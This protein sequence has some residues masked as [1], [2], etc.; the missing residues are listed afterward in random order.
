MRSRRILAALATTGALTGLVACG[1]ND[2][3][4]STR[5][6][7]SAQ[8]I[9]NMPDRFPNVAVKCYRGNG[10]YAANNGSDVPGGIYV[11]VR[12]PAC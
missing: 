10:V 9:I 7:G 2:A 5:D 6:K 4:V 8:A 1:A 12:D 11:V 3:S